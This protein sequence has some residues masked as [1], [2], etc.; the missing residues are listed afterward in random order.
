MNHSV[1]QTYYQRYN[2]GRYHFFTC[3]KGDVIVGHYFRKMFVLHEG[4]SCKHPKT[5]IVHLL[6]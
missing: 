6:E 5:K 1:Q 3:K 4:P 2:R